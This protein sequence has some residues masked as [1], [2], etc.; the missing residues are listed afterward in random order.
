[1]IFDVAWVNTTIVRQWMLIME[2][3][4]A[5]MRWIS[6]WMTLKRRERIYWPF[7]R[8][9]DGC[10]E[11]ASST[12]LAGQSRMIWYAW[13]VVAKR[14]RIL[15]E[16]AYNVLSYKRHFERVSECVINRAVKSYQSTAVVINVNWRYSKPWGL[17]AQYG[18]TN[19]VV[20]EQLH[21]PMNSGMTFGHN[22]SFGNGVENERA[23]TRRDSKNQIYSRE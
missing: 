17:L 3:L 4:L 15:R 2:I 14:K 18:E 19:T 1:M 20:D 5:M 22:T 12:E 7:Y 10:E 23:D 16:I 8:Y 9:D 11:P 6:A 13:V 21:G